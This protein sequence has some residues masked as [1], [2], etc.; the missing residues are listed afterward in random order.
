M[1]SEARL[2]RTASRRRAV[3]FESMSG[4]HDWMAVPPATRSALA[5][6]PAQRPRGVIPVHPTTDAKAILARVMA[7]PIEEDDVESPPP[8]EDRR[9]H[10]RPRKA[11]WRAK[12]RDTGQP[13][14]KPRRRANAPNSAESNKK[15]SENSASTK[16]NAPNGAPVSGAKAAAIVERR[17]TDVADQRATS[18]TEAARAAHVRRQQAYRRRLKERAQDE[19]DTRRRQAMTALAEGHHNR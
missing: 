17:T 13:A 16:T 8:D 11:A 9:E 3:A 14:D 5:D 6:R 15:N 2:P 18:R 19:A 12:R 4:V 10:E 1:P 7:E